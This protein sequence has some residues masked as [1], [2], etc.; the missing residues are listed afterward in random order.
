MS[1]ETHELIAAARARL[2]LERMAHIV[3][4]V[5]RAFQACLERRLTPHGVNFGFWAYLRVLWDQ[6]G[7]S[8]KELSDLV[9][10]TGPTTH[11]VVKRM[12]EAGLIELRPVVEGKPRRAVYL[13]D[14]G[15]SL[16]S[17]LEPLAVDVNT[18]AMSE[19]DEHEHHQLRALM[20]KVHE[21]L[22]SDDL[23]K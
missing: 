6:D 7:L 20:L 16:R 4:E 5:D 10:L 13:S 11:S 22:H 1:N 23:A 15:R 21:S 14:R 17:V 18:L 8:Q 12:E 2:K 3:R 19:L 9:G